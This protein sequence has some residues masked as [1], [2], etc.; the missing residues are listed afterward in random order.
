MA[1]RSSTARKEYSRLRSIARKRID[2]LQKAGVWTS[3]KAN[4]ARLALLTPTRYVA[5]SDLALGISDLSNFLYKQA[6][7]LPAAREAKRQKERAVA[8]AAD[9]L[10]S[11]WGLWIS[12]RDMKSFGDYMEWMRKRAIDEVYD[13]G[14]AVEDFEKLRSAAADIDGV[15]VS[16]ILK[17]FKYWSDHREELEDA[18]NIPAEYFRRARGEYGQT[19]RQLRNAL[20]R[21][22][23]T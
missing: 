4:K 19:S 3:Q 22:Y 17:D 20:N 21:Y 7:T 10:R 5:E 12:D 15:D 16:S 23:N 11:D 1:S 2:R 14:E 13:S 18:R 9:K 6:S 8:A